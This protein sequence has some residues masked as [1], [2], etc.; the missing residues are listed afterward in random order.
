[1]TLAT[2]DRDIAYWRKCAEDAP[3]KQA[4]L[5][6]IGVSMG[7]QMARTDIATSINESADTIA[8]WTASALA[9]GWTNEV[10][11]IKD[12]DQWTRDIQKVLDFIMKRDN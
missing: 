12:M 7:L 1:M 9:S 6:A 5:V 8:K 3:T 4:A 10:H 11:K 2:L